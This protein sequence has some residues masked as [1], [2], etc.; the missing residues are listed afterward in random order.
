METE[1]R[2]AKEARCELEAELKKLRDEKANLI[3]ETRDSISRDAG[4]LQARLN[5]ALSD[6]KKARSE[7]KIEQARRALESVRENLRG[8]DWQAEEAASGAVGKGKIEAGDRVWLQDLQTWGTVLSPPDGEG[9]MDV[10]IGQ[11]RLRMNAGDAGMI[12]QRATQTHTPSRLGRRSPSRKKVSVELDLRGRRADQVQ[13]EL[14]DYL[15]SASFTG[16]SLVRI[17]HG[18]GTGTVKQIVRE[19]LSGHPLVKSFK[20]GEQ[21]EGGNGVTIVEL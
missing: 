13:P 5:E 11:T 16:L 2:K 18:H 8:T 12:E 21:G 17:I 14:E 9:Q 4:R 10:Q 20:A 19:T 6:L 1:E 15:D 3:R 7:E